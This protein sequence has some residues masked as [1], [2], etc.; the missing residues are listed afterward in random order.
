M[1]VLDENIVEGQRE[2]L[3]YWRIRVRQIGVELGRLSMTDEEII[4]LLH[5]LRSVTFFTR[6]RDYYQRRWC[7][8]SYCLVYLSIWSPS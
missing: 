6:D 1:N 5:G 3:A 8:A 4:P 2:L 7:H